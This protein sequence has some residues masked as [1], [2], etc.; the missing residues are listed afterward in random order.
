VKA[1]LKVEIRVEWQRRCF[2]EASTLR[3]RLRWIVFSLA[4]AL[5]ASSVYAQD[6]P[7]NAAG[8]HGRRSI[9][10]ARAASPL[11]VDGNLDEPAWEQARISQEFVQKDPQEGEP[12]TEKTEFR[13]VYTATTL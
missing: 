7:Q 12:S 3:S 9:R 11:V 6:A 4:C 10:A 5:A 13:V 2:R 1:E 8:T